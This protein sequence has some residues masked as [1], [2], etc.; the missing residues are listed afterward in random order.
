M[1]NLTNREI[2]EIENVQRK[3]NLGRNSLDI[4]LIRGFKLDHS[5][6]VPGIYILASKESKMKQV[7][8][9]VDKFFDS[10]F[11]IWKIS[12]GDC[13]VINY[14]PLSER[15]EWIDNFSGRSINQF[16]N[17]LIRKDPQLGKKIGRYKQMIRWYSR[18]FEE[19]M[20]EKHKKYEGG[21]P[22]HGQGDKFFKS[23]EALR[24]D[25]DLW[26]YQKT[27]PRKEVYREIKKSIEDIFH[28]S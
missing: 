17:L 15:V 5:R 3:L 26:R 1:R 16:C 22:F 19:R 6:E 11:L 8:I 9:A 24:I 20:I 10:P 18:S 12:L 4:D 25:S 14:N 27:L 2:L 13:Y 23:E 28:G 21:I 7:D